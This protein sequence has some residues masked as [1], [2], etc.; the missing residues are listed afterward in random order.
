MNNTRH[1]L[2]AASLAALLALAACGQETIVANER[3]D[4]QAAELAKAPPV[5]LPPAIKESKSYRCKD[6]SIVYVNI[7]TDN[8]TV[9]VRSE[10]DKPPTDILVMEEPGQPYTGDDGFSLS[11]IGDTVMF[12]SPG[13]PA[14]SCKA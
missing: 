4:P 10:Q 14:Q 1:P 3:V 12:A 9:N 6:G 5:T 7:L 2:A 11:G 8:K 13:V